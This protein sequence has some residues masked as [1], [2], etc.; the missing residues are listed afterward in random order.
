MQEE[1]RAAFLNR[2]GVTSAGLKAD[3]E[4]VA[5]GWRFLA[6]SQLPFERFFFEWFGGQHAPRAPAGRE[7]HSSE[8]FMAFRAALEPFAP[9]PEIDFTHAYF[10]RPT[11]CTMLIDEVE[12]IWTPI[13]EADDWSRFEA[14]I[15]EIR[16][17]GEALKLRLR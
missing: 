1:F 15:A 13:A 16:Q 17:M 12:D 5:A 10:A 7:E 4:L 6:V 14:K 3:N 2:L 8:A 9:R 11:P